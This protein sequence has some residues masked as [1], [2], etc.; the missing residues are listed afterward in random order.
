MAMMQILD[1]PRTIFWMAICL[2][3]IPVIAIVAA[4]LHDTRYDNLHDEW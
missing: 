4:L 3:V 2:M 1:V